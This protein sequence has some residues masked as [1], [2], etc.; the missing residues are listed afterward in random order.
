MN[1]FFQ[2]FICPFG[3]IGAD[4][5]IIYVISSCSNVEG[6][7]CSFFYLKNFSGGTDCSVSFHLNYTFRLDSSFDALLFFSL[8]SNDEFIILSIY[9]ILK[10]TIIGHIEIQCL[11]F[12]RL[13]MYD[14]DIV[15]E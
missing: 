10:R 7:L 3:C 8:T 11:C 4:I 9:V 5:L 1:R 14:D 6:S 13:N 15:C 2:E 12:V